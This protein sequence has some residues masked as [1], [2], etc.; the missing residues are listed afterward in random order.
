ME[1]KKKF[2]LFDAILGTV[3]LTLVCESVMPTAAIG[4]QQ[5][6]WWIFLLIAFCIKIISKIDETNCFIS[7]C[8][9]LVLAFG[10]PALIQVI[11]YVLQRTPSKI[12]AFL[13]LCG[14]HSLELYLVHEFIFYVLKIHYTNCNP[15]ILF[16]A[17][18]LLSFI[19]AYLSKKAITKIIESF[20]K[21]H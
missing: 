3:C 17:G 2:R 8:V 9:C 15:W 1:K 4:N 14:N 18:F 16:T 11:I 7:N 19:L 10:T 20:S 6:F 13:Q 12:M 21:G 5:Y